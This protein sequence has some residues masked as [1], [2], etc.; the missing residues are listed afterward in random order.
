M[1]KTLLF[2]IPIAA[3]C[4]IPLFS[5]KAADGPQ[6]CS[7]AA[8]GSNKCAN[9]NQYP[10]QTSS[11]CQTKD[12]D[13]LIK[14]KDNFYYQSG[15]GTTTLP[16]QKVCKSFTWHDSN[17]SAQTNSYCVGAQSQNQVCT[18]TENPQCYTQTWKV[19]KNTMN[20]MEC[21]DAAGHSDTVLV[22]QGC[23][24]EPDNNVVIK[25]GR[26]ATDDSINN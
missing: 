7:K 16:N 12:P 5:V 1:K 2:S 8:D 21:K 3:V 10:N 9:V 11:S 22:P 19:C 15:G 4:V 20:N 18:E 23:Q 14:C 25:G 17:S 6:H 26:L 24:S 13:S